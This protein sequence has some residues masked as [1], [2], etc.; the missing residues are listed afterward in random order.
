MTSR[1][2]RAS[3]ETMNVTAMVSPRARPR[4]SI[5]ALITPGRPNGSTAVRI[6]SQRVAP[7]ASAPSLCATGVC[8][9][10]S[11]ES[12]V[13]MGSTMIARTMPM[14]KIVPPEMPVLA[15]SGNQ[16]S[17][18]WRNS[19]TGRTASRKVSTPHRP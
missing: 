13:T 10:T 17:L 2:P 14:K 16:P 15:K 9:N 19:S 7:R 1:D 11:R 5:A 3:V 18:S 12:A 4:A 8:A 6:I